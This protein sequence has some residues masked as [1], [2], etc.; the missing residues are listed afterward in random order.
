MGKLSDIAG[1]GDSCESSEPAP[2]P[3]FATPRPLE[4]RDFADPVARPWG[5]L[6]LAKLE[7]IEAR[8]TAIE[9]SLAQLH[10]QRST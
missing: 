5:N 6:L 3:A 9:K 1:M 4:P 2:R 8:L 7:S 10:D